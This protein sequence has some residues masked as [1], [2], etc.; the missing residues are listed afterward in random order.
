MRNLQRALPGWFSRARSGRQSSQADRATGPSRPR[1]S[2]VPCSAGRSA[3]RTA[4]G[5][6][7]DRHA[8]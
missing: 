2:A 3:Y 4:V 7:N 6:S 5:R 1:W 8:K